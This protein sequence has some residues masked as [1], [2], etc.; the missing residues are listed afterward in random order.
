MKALPLHSIFKE[1][2][3]LYPIHIP[4]HHAGNIAINTVDIR[5]ISIGDSKEQR[6]YHSNI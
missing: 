6:N 3:A 5:Y 2:L 1:Q 4:Y